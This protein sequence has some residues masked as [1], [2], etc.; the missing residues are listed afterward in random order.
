[1]LT[2]PNENSL[3]VNSTVYD[4]EIMDNKVINCIFELD[5]ES[6]EIKR[7]IIGNWFSPQLLNLNQMEI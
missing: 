4:H 7:R 2:L 3:Y 6:L 1:M 5:K